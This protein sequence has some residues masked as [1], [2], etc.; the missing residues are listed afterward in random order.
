[1]GLRWAGILHSISCPLRRATVYIQ[2]ELAFSLNSRQAE[3]TGMMLVALGLSALLCLSDAYAA[4]VRS[5]NAHAKD[6]NVDLGYAR[7]DGY[8]NSTTDLNIWKG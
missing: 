6:L 2:E 7:Y 5:R 3:K 8:Y 1:M 4:T